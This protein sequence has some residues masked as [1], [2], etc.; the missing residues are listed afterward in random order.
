MYALTNNVV[1]GKVRD[2][3][4]NANVPLWIRKI[5][6]RGLR[7]TVERA[8]SVDGR[9][10]G[11]ARQEPGDEA[12]EGGG[13]RRAARCCR[14][15]L[16]VGI[17]QSMADHRAVCGGG[18]AR[19]AGVVGAVRPGE[20]AP[21]RHVRIKNA[22]LHTGKSYAADVHATVSRVLTGY[23]QSWANMYQEA[24]E[25]TQVHGEQS[26]EVLDLRMS[27][28]HE[29][30]GGLRALTDVFTDAN[31]DVV[32]N[33]VSA[34]NA[35]GSLDRCADVA[36]LRSV[37]RPPE[38]PRH[39]REGGRPA[40]PAGGAEGALGR[41]PLERGAEGDAGRRRPRRA[42]IGYQ[43]LVAEILHAGGA[44]CYGRSNDAKAAEKTL[45]EAFWAADASRHDEVR[46]DGR[47]RARVR[48]RLPGGHVRRGGALV[49][50]GGGG[51]AADGRARAAAR[52]AAQQHRRGARPAGRHGGRAA[53]AAAG[54][55]AEGEG[56]RARSPRRRHLRGQHGGRAG[57]AG[58]QSGG[59][60]ARRSG[61]HADRERPGRQPSRRWRR[62][63]ATAA[64]SWPRWAGS[65]RRG[66]RSSGRA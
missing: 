26:A 20:P 6:L 64:R 45:V 5:L 51:A 22:F 33:A 40:P 21:A 29:R 57:R 11:R 28:L 30:L 1:Q 23:A 53:G 38:D 48:V 12:A 55:G 31:G 43:P 62:S 37:V 65:A 42:C 27:C 49:G 35:L 2:A 54:A 56:A 63:S 13:R 17:K 50:N 52:V 58:A 59:A 14:S 47:D 39:A 60:D 66:S 25:A 16:V 9:P 34:A 3:P 10:A 8:V 15:V 32:E 19:L 41:G 61:G 24:C 7:P 36:L 18:P 44:A 4:A 46:A